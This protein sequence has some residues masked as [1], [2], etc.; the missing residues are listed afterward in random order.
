MTGPHSETES[1]GT[2]PISVAELLARNGTIGA[3]A[4]T[5]RRRRRRG[6]S[7]AVSVAELTGELPVIRDDEH[8]ETEQG[9]NGAVQVAEPAPPARPVCVGAPQPLCLL[10]RA[11]RRCW[12]AVV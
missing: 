1:A 3:P 10:L 7:D 9:A 4:V 8:D 5:R 11:G 6:D 2:R 12:T